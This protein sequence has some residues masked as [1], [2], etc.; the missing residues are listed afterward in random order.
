MK[1]FNKDNTKQSIVSKIY[2]ILKIKKVASLK[3]LYK[4]LPEHSQASI[5]GNINRHIA[6]AENKL[7]VRI[8][9]GIYSLI[10]LKDENKSISNKI[11]SFT[12]KQAKIYNIETYLKSKI[13]I[14]NKNIND[15]NQVAGLEQLNIFNIDTQVSNFSYPNKNVTFI[16]TKQAKEIK[17]PKVLQGGKLAGGNPKEEREENDY[18]ATDPNTV[19]LFLKEFHKDNKMN[20]SILECACGEGHI[21]KVLEKHYPNNEI[22]STDLIDRGYG[23]GGI[24]FL[25]H[26]FKRTFDNIITNPPFKFIKEF[27]ERG[28]EL[29]NKF[30][31]MFAKIQLLETVTRKKLFKNSPLKYIYVHSQRQATWKAG[32]PTD[33]KGKKWSTTFCHAWFVWDKSY[34]GE[35]ILRWI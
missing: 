17:K 10:N 20:G 29:S 8:S 4:L 21:S 22:I 2:N 34:V 28:L 33:D 18:Y 24:D 25:T 30:V 12:K 14:F 3:D 7:F 5:R 27:I 26:Q 35:P 16:D 23:I 32:K 31:I 9:K 11:V 19:E 15:V 6:K 13:S 1:Q